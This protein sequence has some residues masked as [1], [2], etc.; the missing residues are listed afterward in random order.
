M[1][2]FLLGYRPAF[3]FSVAVQFVMFVR[4][5]YR[6]IRNDELVRAFVA[7]MAINHLPHIYAALRELC[8]RQGIELNDPPPIRWLDLNSG[9]HR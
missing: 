1:P 5:L 9:P 8:K 3:Y 2:P 6:R 7:E 4:W